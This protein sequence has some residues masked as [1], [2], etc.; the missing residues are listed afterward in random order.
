MVFIVAEGWQNSIVCLVRVTM[1]VGTATI[2]PNE[3]RNETRSGMLGAFGGVLRIE[4]RI[5][6][7]RGQIKRWTYR[8]NPTESVRRL[9]DL[10][11]Q[12]SKYLALSRPY[13]DR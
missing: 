13:L 3:S 5:E 11:R 1:V 7:L 6:D 2:C 8:G 4:R 12:A 10:E 9:K